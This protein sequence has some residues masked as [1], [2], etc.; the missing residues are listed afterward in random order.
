MSILSMIALLAWYLVPGTPGVVT[1]TIIGTI[2]SGIGT[3]TTITAVD[4]IPQFLYWNNA[5]TLQSARVT[6][7]GQPILDLDTA[8]LNIFRS[9]RTN[10]LVTNGFLIPLANQLIT[11]KTMDLTFTNNVAAA[12]TVYGFSIRRN[13][14]APVYIQSLQKTINANTGTMITGFSFLGVPNMA[15]TDLMTVHFSGD[16]PDGGFSNRGSLDQKMEREIVQ[17]LLAYTQ[18]DVNGALPYSVDNADGG[19]SSIDFLPTAAQKIYLQRYASVGS[20][21]QSDLTANIK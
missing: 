12:I 17:A 16:V 5:T 6:V 21:I 19:I 15:T 3:T 10:G 7:N 20:D 4:Y 9:L 18:S 11:G 14:P 8:G 1:A 2:A 13:Q